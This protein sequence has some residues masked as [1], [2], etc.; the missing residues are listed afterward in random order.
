MLGF[1]A[2]TFDES[3]VVVAEERLVVEWLSAGVPDGE[4][5]FARSRDEYFVTQGSEAKCGRTVLSLD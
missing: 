4:A 1:V 2:D 5:E 3:H